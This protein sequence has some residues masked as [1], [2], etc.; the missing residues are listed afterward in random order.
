ME[1]AFKQPVIVGRSEWGARPPKESYS[2]QKPARIV[3]HHS[4]KPE[5]KDFAGVRTIQGIQNYH[6]D[7]PETGW[8]DIGYHFLLPPDGLIYAGRPVGVVGAHCGN[9]PKRGSRRRFSNRGSI[10]IMVGGNFDPGHDHPTEAQIAHLTQLIV[11]LQTEYGIDPK[12][13][14]GHRECHNPPMAGKTCPGAN[15]FIPMLG[16]NR[17]EE[18]ERTAR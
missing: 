4:W 18:I 12:E 9:T 11:W 17:W 6:M 1:I 2:H 13:I 10:G 16:Q 5:A 3:L 15:L 8:N 7:D 14:Y